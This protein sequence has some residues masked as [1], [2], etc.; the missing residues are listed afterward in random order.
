MGTAPDLAV[1]DKGRPSDGPIR[2]LVVDDSPTVRAVFARLIDAEPDLDVVACEG[3]AEEALAT[4]LQTAPDVI[5]LDLEMPGMGG[6]D[7]I[8][9]MLE[10]ASPA[11]VLVVSSLT[12]RGAEHTLEALSLGAAD[13]LELDLQSLVIEGLHDVVVGARADRLADV[14][15]V[16]LG[17]AEHHLGPVTAFA[18]AKLGDELDPGHHRHVPIEQHHIGH[19]FGA[20]VE[21]FLAILGFLDPEAERF[22]YVSGNLADD[23]RIIDDKAGFHGV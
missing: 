5:L 1:R 22:E 16:V 18:L 15:D 6:L 23:P 12:V 9:R 4:L 3:T 14:R 7:A 13:T 19:R 11:R 2:V 21:A 10:L 8:P 20:F 17:G